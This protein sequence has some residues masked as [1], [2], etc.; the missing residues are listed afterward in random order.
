[1]FSHNRSGGFSRHLELLE[2]IPQEH[3]DTTGNLKR[4]LGFSQ[5]PWF[6]RSFSQQNGAYPATYDPFADPF[7][8]RSYIDSR[9]TPFFFSLWQ[10]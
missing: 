4:Y 5:D 8:G 3:G 1:M 2:G 7:F 9:I 10:S 6:T